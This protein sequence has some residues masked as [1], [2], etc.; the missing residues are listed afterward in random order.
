VGII[1]GIRAIQRQKSES[2]FL[3]GSVLHTFY[4]ETEAK[5]D[6]MGPQLGVVLARSVGRLSMRLQATAMAGFNFGIVQQK[7]AL[8][9]GLVPGALN[10]P[11]YARPAQ[12]RHVDPH[13][14]ISPSGELRVEARYRLSEMVTFAIS[15]SGVAIGNALVTDDRTLYQ[16]PELGLVDPGEQT[17]L[18]HNLFCGLEMML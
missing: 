13:D 8:G 5:N 1:Y 14:E 15:W 17:I 4:W 2:V 10:Q 7:G 6:I 18:V 3:E 9:E 11:L 12:F 16:I